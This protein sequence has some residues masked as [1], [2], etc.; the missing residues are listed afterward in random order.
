M[1]RGGFRSE[2]GR[3]K[4]AK[5]RRTLLREEA[6]RRAANTG[7]SPLEFLLRIMRDENK[8]KEVRIAG[9]KAALPYCLPRLSASHVTV[10]GQVSHEVWLVRLSKEIAKEDL[11]PT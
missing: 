4:G 5:N 3:P 6:S 11:R 2:A 7:V 1:A 8:S 9:A 10:D